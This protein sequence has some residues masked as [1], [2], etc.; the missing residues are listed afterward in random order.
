[1]RIVPPKLKYKPIPIKYLLIS[2]GLYLIFIFNML[3]YFSDKLE[4]SSLIE[5]R[6]LVLSY[7]ILFQLVNVIILVL[8][9]LL[10]KGNYNGKYKIH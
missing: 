1:M 3:V 9:F 2:L 10:T 6:N 7:E 8:A 4:I 5:L